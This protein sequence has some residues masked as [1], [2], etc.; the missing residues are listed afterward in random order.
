MH[1]YSCSAETVTVNHLFKSVV[2]KGQAKHCVLWGFF[3][4]F[5]Y[6]H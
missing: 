4:L 6:G 3:I 5:S 2:L 1:N